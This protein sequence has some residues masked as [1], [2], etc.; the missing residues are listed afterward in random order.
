MKIMLIELFK[1]VLI[2][3]WLI[4]ISIV[5]YKLTLPEEK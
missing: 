3:G 4:F 1:V 5:L 2:L